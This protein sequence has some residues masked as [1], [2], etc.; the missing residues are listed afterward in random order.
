MPM[1]ATA[2]LASSRCGQIATPLLGSKR[3]WF[4]Y[5]R[6]AMTAEMYNRRQVI[7]RK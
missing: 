1:Y 5:A 7:G 6:L 4:S 3:V 2:A